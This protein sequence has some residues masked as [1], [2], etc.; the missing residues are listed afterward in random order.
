MK[1]TRPHI[2]LTSDVMGQ[3]YAMTPRT[4]QLQLNIK[5]RYAVLVLPIA[6]HAEYATSSSVNGSLRKLIMC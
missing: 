4:F 2:L 5:T 3:T 6:K 1:Q